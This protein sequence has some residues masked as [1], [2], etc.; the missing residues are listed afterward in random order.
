MSD[1]GDG[2][3][4]LHPGQEL[5]RAN[6]ELLFLVL[7]HHRGFTGSER[8]APLDFVGFISEDDLLAGA[9]SSKA[10]VILLWIDLF[11]DPLHSISRRKA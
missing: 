10:L 5:L 4:L 6:N 1:P 9:E 8:R 3:R 7:Q 11:H 2:V